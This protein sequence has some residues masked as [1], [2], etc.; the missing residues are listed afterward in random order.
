MLKDMDFEVKSHMSVVSE[1]ML[2]AITRKIQEEKQSSIAEVKRQKAKKIAESKVIPLDKKHLKIQVEAVVAAVEAAVVDRVEVRVEAV[3]GKRWTQSGYGGPP[4][5]EKEDGAR[6]RS[7]RRGKRDSDPM[8]DMRDGL[9]EK[10]EV[11]A[12]SA[13]P[14]VDDGNRGGA[15]V[16]GLSAAAVEVKPSMPRK[17]RKIC[18][19]R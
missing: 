8:Q 18:A 17:C 5:P 19:A 1:D 10:R 9:T 7:K 15:D 6:R 12:R 16:V 4:A 11:T 2:N 3:E 13:A 14:P